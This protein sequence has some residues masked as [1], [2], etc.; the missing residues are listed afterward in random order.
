MSRL[1]NAGLS[2]LLLAIVLGAQCSADS[3]IHPAA[4]TAPLQVN[5]VPNFHHVTENIYRGGQPTKEGFEGL[6]K[7]GIKTVVNLR[8]HHSD[9]QLMRGRS[10]AYWYI[11]MNAESPNPE[12]MEE[13]LKILTDTRQ[14]PIFVHCKY[15]ADRT[16][17]VMAIYRIKVQK[18][19]REDA[20]REMVEGGYGFHRMFRRL[21]KFVEE[22]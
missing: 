6:E 10:F 14:Y 12:R 2:C 4:W 19:S 21:K 18:W 7:L 3:S 17:A 16:G 15:G 11:P 5:G 20:V 8:E 22:Y 13:A 9:E 1:T